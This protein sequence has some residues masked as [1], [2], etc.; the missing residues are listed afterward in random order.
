MLWDA[1]STQWIAVGRCGT[2]EISGKV[3]GGHRGTTISKRSTANTAK[4]ASTAKANTAKAANTAKTN[5]AKAAN[6]VSTASTTVPEKA[7]KAAN[8]T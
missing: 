2:R 1:S 6:T 7:A 4:I 5:S 3:E 8:A